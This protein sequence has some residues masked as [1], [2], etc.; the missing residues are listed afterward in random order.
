MA[1]ASK[2]I[3]FVAIIIACFLAYPYMN[4]Q[5]ISAF[6]SRN[7]ISAPALFIA[8][9]AVR[10]VLFF[11]PSMGL[12]IAAGVLFGAIWGTVYVA[13]GGALSTA[14]GYYFAK[15]LGRDAAKKMIE[16]HQRL[17]E[18]EARA[19]SNSIITVLSMRL[20]NLP[21]D[22]VSYWA[23]LQGIRFRDFYIASMIPLIPV[24]FL[25]TY[26]GSRV[27]NPYSAGFIISLMIMFA[28]GAIPC[29]KAR[30]TERRIK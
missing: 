23:G 21:W 22:I 9:C 28:M 1:S 25:Y 5:D 18:W 10:P 11:L 4:P 3:F 2:I 17:R 24:S 29:I 6:I 8:I 30:R 26:F 19:Q 27:F 15:W 20:F 13:I 14:V 12:T 7:R 16:R